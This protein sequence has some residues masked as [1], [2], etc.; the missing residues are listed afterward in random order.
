MPGYTVTVMSQSTL[1][2]ICG[3]LGVAVCINL[4]CCDSDPSLVAEV[5]S[6]PLDESRVEVSVPLKRTPIDPSV[7]SDASDSGGVVGVADEGLLEDGQDALLTSLYLLVG[8]LEDRRHDAAVVGEFEK[9]A[10]R[11]IEAVSMKRFDLVE[12]KDAAS[13]YVEAINHGGEVVMMA[14]VKVRGVLYRPIV[15]LCPSN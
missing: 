5:D 6:V 4:C 3:V 9:G 10:G 11:L 12:V 14:P 13:R 7:G 2:L 1:L 15:R 8:S